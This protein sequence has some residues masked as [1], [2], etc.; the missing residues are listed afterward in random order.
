[1]S[2]ARDW[3]ERK[4]E[5]TTLAARLFATRGYNGAGIDDI[6]TA[7]GLSGPALYRHFPS[8]QHILAAILERLAD[9]VVTAIDGDLE[10][11]LDEVVSRLMSEGNSLA[12][13]LRQAKHLEPGF[14]TAE[15]RNVQRR[16][17]NAWR[18]Y[19]RAH[20]PE[21][22]EL[23]AVV[24][25]RAAAGAVVSLS[26]AR[27]GSA[28]FRSRLAT[29]IVERI[30]LL[31]FPMALTMPQ[32]NGERQPPDLA[33]LNGAL[34][35]EAILV[36][37]ARQFAQKGF[38]GTSLSDIGEMVGISA[39]AVMRHFTSKEGL[40]AAAF[41]RLAD[42][43]TANIYYE[44]VNDVTP[45]TRLSNLVDSYIAV[46]IRNPD[47]VAVNMTELRFLPVEDQRERRRSQ[48]MYVDVLARAIAATRPE[49]SDLESHLRARAAYA[50]VNEVIVDDRLPRLVGITENLRPLAVAAAVPG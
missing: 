39:S 40:L 12:V 42:N 17:W 3:S 34:R 6:G 5:L 45:I 20:H 37:S 31:E 18:D 33:S 27:S 15:M 28:A 35:R 48:R 44:I 9:Q 30:L 24:R 29:E 8:K 4:A 41:A 2:A 38:N 7:A 14:I 16:L 32:P 21:D 11:N 36:V 25:S 23:V 46:A 50:L 47:L 19:L 13:A 43:I 1:V 22:D 26:F 10:L 49:L